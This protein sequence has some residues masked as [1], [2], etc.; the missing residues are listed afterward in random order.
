MVNTTQMQKRE[1][2][3][4]EM[5]IA[6][7]DYNWRQQFFE[8]IKALAARKEKGKSITKKKELVVLPIAMPPLAKKGNGTE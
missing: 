4:D 7:V 3:I 2:E 8:D 6:F 1:L 5:I